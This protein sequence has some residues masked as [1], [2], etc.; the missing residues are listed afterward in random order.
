LTEEAE[1]LITTIKQM[2]SSLEGNGSNYELDHEL[3]ISFPLKACLQVLKEKHLA[4]SRVHQERYE[5]VKSELMIYYL[6]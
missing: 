2:H 4:V 1:K 6:S 3:K 5:Q